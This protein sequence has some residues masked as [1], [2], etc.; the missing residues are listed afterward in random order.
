[1]KGVIVKCIEE[2]IMSAA[3][4]QIWIQILEK[5]GFTKHQI[6]LPGTDVADESV[7]KI[8]GSTCEVT[9]KSQQ[10][11]F[12]LFGEYWINVYNPKLYGHYFNQIKSARE[13]ILKLNEIHKATTSNMEGARPPRFEFE[14]VSEKQIVVKYISHRGL[15]DIYISIVKGMAKKFNEKIGIEKISNEQVRLIFQK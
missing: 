10:E 13:L 4:K 15:I 3:G 11:V 1:M 6:F 7:I 9:G 14:H 8:I 5:S 12:D 2:L